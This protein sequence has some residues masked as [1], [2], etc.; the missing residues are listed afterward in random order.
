MCRFLCGHNLSPGG[1]EPVHLSVAERSYP[2]SEVR[3]GQEEPPCVRGQG[4]SGEAASRPR[5][6]AVT[7]RSHPGL[8]SGA[9]AGKRHPC[10]RP[11]PVARR[12]NPRSGGFAGTGGPRGDTYVE[13]QEQWQ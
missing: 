11:G 12:S 4:L 10:P 6:G 7:L 2:T 8:R 1:G 9:A 3:G 5:P 13:G